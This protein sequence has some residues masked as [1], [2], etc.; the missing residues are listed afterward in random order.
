MAIEDRYAVRVPTPAVPAPATKPA[1]TTPDNTAF[2]LPPAPKPVSPV[3][4][5]YMDDFIR[6]EK[7][8]ADQIAAEKAAADK[9]LKDKADADKAKADA[10]KA[11]ADTEALRLAKEAEAK[12]R[13]LAD[14]AAAAQAALVTQIENAKA[15]AARQ[16][17]A[18]LA[19]EQ[20]KVAA[21]T[22]QKNSA[23]ALAAQQASK[24]A[25][26]AIAALT[27]R[28]TRYNLTS[29]IPKIKE[30]AISG[31][32]QD[33]ITLQLQETPEYQKRF[34]ANQ[35]RVKKNLQVL[36]A[37]D[38]LNVE[39]AYRQVL[40]SYGL[41]QFDNDEYVS[42][43]IANDMS[44][45]TLSNRVVTAV[46]RIRNADPA[47]S[48]T[49]RRYYGIGTSDLVAY[50]LDPEQQFEKIQRQVAAAEI[51]TAAGLQG[52]EPGVAVA[53]QLASQGISQAEAQKGYSTIADIL[54]T[55][56]KLSQIYGTET[57]YTQAT[58][59][60]EVF[61]SLASAQRTRRKLSEREIGTFSGASGVARGLK[62]KAESAQ[63]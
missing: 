23:A 49:L 8:K 50:V 4:T 11:K 9:L 21:L 5:S 37:S 18:A 33:T 3:D 6:R 57:A 42:Q 36:S 34:R 32:T 13:A 20:A 28:F 44:P 47:I 15:E 63:F 48:T 1:I 19:L 62:S 51:G 17:S 14:Q 52:F 60:Q 2:G 61:N 58:A 39:D 31:A 59:E 27:E 30:L 38:Y 56:D 43:F 16:A 41:T 55:A 22:A 45:T 29:L 24:E 7:V 40:R 12:S 35:E 54:P 46:Q 26:D 25:N 10:D 53:E